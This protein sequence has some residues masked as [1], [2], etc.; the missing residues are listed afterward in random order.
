[1]TFRESEMEHMTAEDWIILR[2]LIVMKTKAERLFY[3]VEVI[4]SVEY[5]VHK[6]GLDV[7][8]D[9]LQSI[10]KEK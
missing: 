10:H 3:D 5:I 6:Y 1:M 8:C 7:F 2:L 4:R 9:A